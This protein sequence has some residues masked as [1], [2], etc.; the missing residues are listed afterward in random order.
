MGTPKYMPRSV[1]GHVCHG[2][3]DVQERARVRVWGRI[4]DNCL[5]QSGARNSPPRA[6]PRRPVSLFWWKVK[7]RRKIYIKTGILVTDKLRALSA[8][9]TRVGSVFST[10]GASGRASLKGPPPLPV[11]LEQCFSTSCRRVT[12]E[13]TL[14]GC[15]F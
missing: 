9:I 15:A 12:C 14:V 13:I 3:V 7:G 1:C 4:R 11:A 2:G 6:S 10:L 8:S 5:W